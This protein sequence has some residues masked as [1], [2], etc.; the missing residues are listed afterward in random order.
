[1]L[2]VPT[3]LAPS[4]IHGIGLFAAEPFARGTLLWVFQPGLDLLYDQ[5]FIDSLPELARAQILRHCYR[6]P[7]SGLYVL[8]GDDA[9]FWNHAAE[10]NTENV[11][12]PDNEQGGTAATRDIQR[13]EELTC[14][15][16]T[17]DDMERE[18]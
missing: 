16:R 1:M 11:E 15:Y 9:R 6:D 2:L 13:G 4:P 8:C 3:Y 7:D 17:F 12:L 10:P 5:A 18:I 14:D